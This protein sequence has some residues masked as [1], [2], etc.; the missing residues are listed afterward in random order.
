MTL[1]LVSG[2]F[3]L[4]EADLKIVNRQKSITRDVNKKFIQVGAVYLKPASKNPIDDDWFAKTKGMTDLQSWIDD[5]EQQPLN[6]GFNM[7]FGWT[8]ADID[9]PD[10][11]YNRFILAAMD[12]LQVD[13]R[14]RFG[15]LSVGYPTHLLVQ[16]PEDEAQNH[17]KLRNFVPKEIHL[18]GHRHHTDIRSYGGEDEKGKAEREAKQ[19]VM[20]GSLYSPKRDIGKD[21]DMSVWYDQSGRIASDVG[22]IAK[23]T[24]RI[25]SFL[26]IVRAIAFG[27]IAYALKDQWVTGSRQV[28]A[29]K[30]TGW[31]ARVVKECA[32]MSEHEV[33]GKEVFCPIDTDSWAEK[34]IHFLCAVFED[35]EPHM[36]A[37][38]YFDASDKLARNPDAKIPGWISMADLIG[39]PGV[40]ALR[41]VMTPGADISSLTRMA[42]R[43][44]YDETDNRYIDRERHKHHA[45]YVHEAADLERRHK[46]DV[47]FLGGK[48]R[49]SFKVFESSNI[50]RRVDGRDNWPDHLPGSIIRVSGMGHIVSDDYDGVAT[51]YYNT[52]PGWQVEPIE[53]IDPVVMD[54]VVEMMDRMFH[55]LTSDNLDQVNW[56]KDWI[57][58]I[59]QHPGTKQ[60]IALVIIGGQGVGKSFWGHTFMK[61]LLGSRHW[62]TASPKVVDDKF[63]IGPFKE[64]L[65]TMIDEAKFSANDSGSVEEIKKLI[66]NTDV[67]GMEKY[68]EARDYR[69]YA[70][71]AFASNLFNMNISQRN[72]VDRA[73]FYA[74]AHSASS[75]KM[76]EAEFKAWANTLKPFYDEF[77]K[78]LGDSTFV[79]HMIRYFVDRPVDRHKIESIEFSS[80]DDEDVVKANMGWAR[81]VAKGIIES[82]YVAAPD[83]AFEYPFDAVALADRVAAECKTLGFSK[84]TADA[85]V[86]EFRLCGLYEEYN[87]DIGNGKR[88]SRFSRKW[89]DV[90]KAYGDAVGI[91]LAPFRRL[92]PEDF[93]EN[94]ATTESRSLKRIGGRANV[95]AF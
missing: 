23:T 57:A 7:Q 16:L 69:V 17:S 10:P 21:Y 62:G 50:R 52:W 18:N 87:E 4:E 32:A 3:D 89:G 26:N 85:V 63:N 70:R 37:R 65:F 92:L 71:I 78:A 54:R 84:M 12:F 60:Q 93:G 46:G 79:R 35:D 58:W 15:R 44:I 75:M 77:A 76:S 45:S 22:S 68:E 82:G 72:T 1:R 40:Q 20:P 47:I 33:V 14:F 86:G 5:P 90:L 31:L 28:T 34:L 91:E 29:T 43:Y 88:V 27:T 38:T 55:L 66:R 53:K 19:T 42:E 30:V 61:A 49:E 39:A 56:I 73:L 11:D 64:K 41:T 95:S 8:D 67:A 83:L 9:S 36:R 2:G 24:A 25:T 80:G 59:R 74:R 48:P 6:V 13:T 81:R 94:D 51:T